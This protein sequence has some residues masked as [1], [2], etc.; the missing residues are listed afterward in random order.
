ME[1][2]ITVVS[3]YDHDGNYLFYY[4]AIIVPAKGD[5]LSRGSFTYKVKYLELLVERPG[6]ANIYVKARK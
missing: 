4:D 3:V 2:V 5:L 6:Q 1:N